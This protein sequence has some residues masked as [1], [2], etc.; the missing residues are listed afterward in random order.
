MNYRHSY[1]AGNFADVVKHVILIELL[2]A[3]AKK[4]TPYC[5]IDT[6]AGT[7][8]YDLFSDHAKKSQEFVNG[9]EKVIQHN[10]PPPLIKQYLDYVHRLNNKLSGAKY[11]SLQYYPGSPMIARYMAR[12]HD[13][14]VAC[15][16]QPQEYESLRE[17]FAGDKQVAIHHTD[18]FLGLKAFLPPQERRGLVL[19]DPPYENP[20]EF[21]RIAHALPVALKRWETGIYAIWYP[22][23]EKAQT[24]RF[25]RTLK[26]HIDKPILAI[27][28]TIYPDLPQHLNGCGLVIINP[29]WQFDTA[30]QA[31]LPW[32]W[33]A[34]T[35]NDQGA[36][37][38]QILK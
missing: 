29:P 18:G 15:E 27:E 31:V 26:E 37:R 9:I 16:L 24:E 6:H 34:L 35:I 28:L 30:M 12:G 8:Y 5:Y 3:L 4:N 32:L 13:R 14:I 19:I 23:K 33:K 17:T 2:A 20:D 36:F 25:Y 1:H 22:I 21:T 7:G 38:T 10:N 11:A